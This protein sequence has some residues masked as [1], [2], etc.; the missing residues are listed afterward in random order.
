MLKRKLCTS[1][2]ES[3]PINSVYQTKSLL[4]AS[5]SNYSNAAGSKDTIVAFRFMHRRV[6]TS[7]CNLILLHFI[8]QIKDKLCGFVRVYDNKGT[9][10]RQRNSNIRLLYVL[11]GFL[12]LKG[13]NTL[14]SLHARLNEM[15]SPNEFVINLIVGSR[16]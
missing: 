5:S 14:I 2:V 8:H 1:S 12:N 10:L 15:S 11:R 13:R 4:M 3:V 16:S 9:P 7:T 6:V